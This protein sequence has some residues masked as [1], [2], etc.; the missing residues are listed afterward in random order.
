MLDEVEPA[1]YADE[2]GVSVDNLYNIKKRAI[3][4]FS[5]I[6]VKYYS[7]GR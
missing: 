3:A 5:Q 1:R 2:I 4:A 6:A 7:Y